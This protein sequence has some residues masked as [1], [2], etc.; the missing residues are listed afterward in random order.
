[1]HATN[2]KNSDIGTAN[3]SP[4][5]PIMRGAKANAIAMN[6]KLRKTVNNMDWRIF[7]MLCMNVII[8]M[9]TPENKYAM[10]NSSNPEH[11]RICA[12]IPGS[13]K[14]EAIWSEKI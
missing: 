11:A 5:L 6:T 4:E 12:S 3:Q 9:L 7:S 1:M 2:V 10:E 8:I 14:M 13:R